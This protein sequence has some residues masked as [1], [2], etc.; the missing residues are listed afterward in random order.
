MRRGRGTA[1]RRV[2]ELP[3]AT[4]A[5]A[6]ASL[7]WYVAEQVG[8]GMAVCQTLGFTPLR[9][10]LDTA[11]TSIWLHD[12]AGVAHIAGNLVVLL[13]VGIV[14]EPV[15]GGGR[16]FALFVAS[17]VGGALV[18][19]VVEPDSPVPLVGM[20]GS[21]TG[22]MAVAAA[23]RPR[24]MLG[25]VVSYI[26]MNIVALFVANPLIPPGVSVGAHIGGFCVGVMGV[27]V[28][29]I[30]ANWWVDSNRRE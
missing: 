9:P 13:V 21:L 3:F 27:M 7:A 26:G 6:T 20:S 30:R 18:H 24:L 1:V 28:E 29:R 14:V 2:A 12:P 22:L 19:L 15:F 5:I 11:V 4:L 10:S 8:G 17:G 23:A 16:L 25:F